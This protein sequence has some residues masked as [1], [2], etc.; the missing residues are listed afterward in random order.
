MMTRNQTNIGVNG[1]RSCC[2]KWQSRRGYTLASTPPSSAAKSPICRE[3][4]FGVELE[5]HLQLIEPLFIC[6]D[7]LALIIFKKRTGVMIS[8]FHMGPR[9]YS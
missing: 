1:V 8:P 4:S 5:L 6:I 3:H 9:D 2:L 7:N